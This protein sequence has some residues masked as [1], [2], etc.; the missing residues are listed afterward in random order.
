MLGSIPIVYTFYLFFT[1][2]LFLLL[3]IL[4]IFCPPAQSRGREN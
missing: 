1:F 4:F 2:Y 3:F